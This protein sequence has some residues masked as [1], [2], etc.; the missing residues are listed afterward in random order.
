M[1]ISANGEGQGGATF[2]EHRAYWGLCPKVTTFSDPY[3]YSY[4]STSAQGAVYEYGY[5]DV[6]G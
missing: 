2:R 4:T 6:Y 3:T 5:E 1:S